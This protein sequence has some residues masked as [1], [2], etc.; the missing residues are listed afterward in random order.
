MTQRDSWCQSE[1]RSQNIFRHRMSVENDSVH[2]ELGMLEGKILALEC[3][4]KATPINASSCGYTRENSY[5]QLKNYQSRNI[6]NQHNTNPSKNLLFPSN[7]LR[8][9]VNVTVLNDEND[10]LNRRSSRVEIGSSLNKA[11]K[12]KDK[13]ELKQT[14]KD[15]TKSKVNIK[16]IQKDLWKTK[17]NN[18]KEK[19]IIVSTNYNNISNRCKLLELNNK[20]QQKR[21]KE[22]ER[23]LFTLNKP[24]PY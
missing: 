22:L 7:T 20:Q 23:K 8:N 2:K 15:K 19:Y 6:I 14:Q 10:I 11:K 1:N 21:I 13:L 9:S 16:L 3:K 4:L 24:S 18:L 5:L 17:Y 12:C